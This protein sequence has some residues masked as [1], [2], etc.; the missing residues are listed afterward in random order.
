MRKLVDTPGLR[1]SGFRISGLRGFKV[2]DLKVSGLGFWVWSSAFWG[3][4][5]RR[6]GFGIFSVPG[7]RFSEAQV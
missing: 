1:A 7:L 5:C 6:L 3:F 4:T 2:Q